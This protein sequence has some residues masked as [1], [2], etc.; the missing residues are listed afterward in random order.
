MARKAFFL[1]VACAAAGLTACHPQPSS[2]RYAFV[3][4]TMR[5]YSIQPPIIRAKQGENVEL[6]VSTSDVQ[7]GFQVPDL[8]INEPV[9]P[10]K[11]VK[12]KLDTSQKG[13]FEVLCSIICG[14]GHDD[15]RS[16]IVIE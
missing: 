2:T 16:K 15:M 11:P 7:H 6:D 10:G 12:I 5:K 4:V 9:Q 14:P 13:E 1:L 3:I 8:G